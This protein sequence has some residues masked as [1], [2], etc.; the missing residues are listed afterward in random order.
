MYLYKITIKSVIL[1]VYTKYYIL[2][3]VAIAVN[4]NFCKKL[5]NPSG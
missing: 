1:L 4:K 2:N 5:G 3:K